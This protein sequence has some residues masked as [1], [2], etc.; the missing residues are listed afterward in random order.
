MGTNSDTASQATQSSSL[1]PM[2]I[3]AIGEVLNISMGSAATAV[4]TMLD[5][6][7]V[8][9]TPK[10]KVETLESIKTGTLEPA[11]IVKITYTEGITGSNVMVFRQNDMQLILNQLMGIDEPPSPDFIFDELS[12][13]AACEVMNQMMGASATALSKFL[14][15]AINISTPTA[16]VMDGQKSFMDAVGLEAEDEIVSV[17]FSLNIADVISSEFVSVLSKELA[18]EIIN[19]FINKE[20]EENARAAA[21][22]KASAPP[23]Q[24]QAPPP[25]QQQAPPPMQQQAPPPMQQQAPPPM[26][27]QA[28]PPMQQQA[29]PP[30][31]QQ[32]PPQMQPPYGYPPQVPYGYP[33]QANYGYPPMQNGYAVPEMVQQR[34]EQQAP[35][36]VKPVQFADFNPAPVSG[37]AVMGGNMNLIMNVPLNVSIEIGK[38]KRKI[39]DIMNFTQGTVIELEKQAGA[40]VDIIVNGQLLAHGDVVVIDDNFG[41]RITEIVGTKELLQSLEDEIK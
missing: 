26:Q 24:Q 14:G 25:M 21:E 41:V 4:S 7:V 17:L 35:L 34:V 27:Q 31:Q 5:K 18:K 15:K 11:I 32:V 12:M 16:V 9:T 33:P 36:N 28:P 39:K 20:D 6:Q 38:T 22:H 30:M 23:I 8:I 1:S 37:A 2:E 13:S 19:D 40:P 10:V 29:P 3:D